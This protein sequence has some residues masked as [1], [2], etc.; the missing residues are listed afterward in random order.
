MDRDNRSLCLLSACLRYV[1]WDYMTN[2]PLRAR[3]RDR[4]KK[5][6]HSIQNH[7]RDHRI[8]K[9]TSLQQIGCQKNHEICAMVGVKKTRVLFDG[10][11]MERDVLF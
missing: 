7:K 9:N 2:T 5:Q 10:Y 8:Q 11:L 4:G 6:C 1:Q 3:F